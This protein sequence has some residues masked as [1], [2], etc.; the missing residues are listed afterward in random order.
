MLAQT[1][2]WAIIGKFSQI[3]PSID[4][5]RREFT[6]IIPGK[7]NIK[8]RAYDM[9]H[10][11][12]DFDNIEDHLNVLSRNFIHLGGLDIMKIMKWSTTFKPNSDHSLAPVWVNL[13][14]LKWHLFEWDAICRILEPIGTPLLLDKATL[15]KTRPT[16]AKVRVEIDLTKPFID[17]VILEITNRDGLTEMINQRTEYETIPAFCSVTTQA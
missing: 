13:P 2:K 6:K 4:I 7:G 17:E 11:F 3:R 1:C 10:V 16:I 15:T 12:L 14:D 9:H 5:I 8:I